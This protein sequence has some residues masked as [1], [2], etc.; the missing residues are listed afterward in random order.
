MLRCAPTYVLH[1]QEVDVMCGGF[2]KMWCRGEVRGPHAVAT[3][4]DLVVVAESKD[5]LVHHGL[6]IYDVRPRKLY[7]HDMRCG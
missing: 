1:G 2:V 5:P 7:M 6:C 3:S 4:L